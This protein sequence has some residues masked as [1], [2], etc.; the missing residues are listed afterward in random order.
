MGWVIRDVLRPYN[1]ELSRTLSGNLICISECNTLVWCQRGTKTDE[2]LLFS[3]S[4]YFI[5]L[6]RSCVQSTTTYL[7]NSSSASI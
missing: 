7:L 1:L 6:R 3:K 5:C 2:H 4:K